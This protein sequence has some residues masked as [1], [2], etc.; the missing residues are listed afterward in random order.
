MQ[1]TEKNY[2]QGLI[3]RKKVVTVIMI[4]G[5][6]M[7]GTIVDQDQEAIFFKAYGKETED[8]QMLYKHAVS[9]V[10]PYRYQ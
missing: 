4:N 5:F 7:Q 9:T 2:L 1:N 10:T 3:G 8:V 6:Q